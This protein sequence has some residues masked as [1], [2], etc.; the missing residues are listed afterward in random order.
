MQLFIGRAVLILDKCLSL[1]GKQY[2]EDTMKKSEKQKGKAAVAE[3]KQATKR[4]TVAGGLIV[5]ILV[6]AGFFLLYHPD[7]A[8]NGDAVMVYYTGSYE[9]GTQFYS[10]FDD[11]SPLIFTIGNHTVIAG[12][13]EA[14]IGMTPNSTK[15]V[16][17]SFDKAYGPYR[18]DYVL[19]MNRSSL[20]ADINPV[21]GNFYSIVRKEDQAVARVRITNVTSDTVTLDEN[22]VLAGQNLTFFIKFVGYYKG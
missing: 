20:P 11:D 7:A 13:E 9:N 3:R 21:V 22:H 1:Q 17:I 12:M 5:I 4:F 8:K 15:T 6:V 18:P 19:V 16:N 10:N 2:G 14:V